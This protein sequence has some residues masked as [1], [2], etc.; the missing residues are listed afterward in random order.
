[1]AT[2]VNNGANY[3]VIMCIMFYCIFC[4]LSLFVCLAAMMNKWN[5]SWQSS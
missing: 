3:R 5:C 1:M 4:V 2:R